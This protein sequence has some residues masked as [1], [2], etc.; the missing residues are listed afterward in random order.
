M[1]IRFAVSAGFRYTVRFITL[2]FILLAVSPQASARL[3]GVVFDDSASMA[4]TFLTPLHALQLLVASLKEGDRMFVVKM[5]N[6]DAVKNVPDSYSA[7][8]EFIIKIGRDWRADGETP[9]E[10]VVTALHALD[11]QGKQGEEI[12]LIVLTDGEFTEPPADPA[13][14]ITSLKQKTTG[15]TI[16]I[17]FVAISR[18]VDTSLLDAISLQGVRKELLRQFNGDESVGKINLQSAATFLP[19][20]AD[21]IATVHGSDPGENVKAIRYQGNIIEFTPPFAINELTII[22]SGVA[23]APAPKIQSFDFKK[24]DSKELS[25]KMREPDGISSEKISSSVLHLTPWP[26]LS[27]GNTYKI[28]FDRTVDAKKVRL[29][30][31]TSVVVDWALL[32]DKGTAL[33]PD[34]HGIIRVGKDESLVARAKL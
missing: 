32:N 28:V 12:K 29:I 9:F 7:R 5:S 17:S 10:S 4:N 21:L 2:C 22:S 33:V 31:N 26:Q 20:M 3:I 25:G 6:P 34:S 11:K 27:G 30:F 19:K 14:Y 15:K 18:G 24:I 8:Q 23:A 1:A 13:A 16:D